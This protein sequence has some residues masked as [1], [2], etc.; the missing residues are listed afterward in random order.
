MCKTSGGPEDK[1]SPHGIDRLWG[2]REQKVKA[3]RNTKKE[4]SVVSLEQRKLCEAT[5]EKKI[6]FDSSQ[7]AFKLYLKSGTF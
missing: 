4:N 6:G 1:V 2:R 5:E 7:V 3:P